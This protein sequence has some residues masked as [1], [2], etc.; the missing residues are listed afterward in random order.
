CFEVWQPG[1]PSVGQ[2]W[3]PPEP[4]SF[5][6]LQVL[7]QEVAPFLG[8]FES[9]CTLDPYPTREHPDNT[10]P[11]LRDRPGLGKQAGY[12]RCDKLALQLHLRRNGRTHRFEPCRYG[13][14]AEGMYRDRFES[15]GARQNEC[16][17]CAI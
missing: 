17:Q 9:T 1:M 3:S 10:E 16:L 12:G 14:T 13:P 7:Q 4:K 6:S 15:I 5:S 8:T 11:C 2:V